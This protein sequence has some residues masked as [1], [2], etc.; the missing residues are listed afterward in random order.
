MGNKPIIRLRLNSNR[1][2]I[3]KT[4]IAS[5]KRRLKIKSSPQ[6]DKNKLIIKNGANDNVSA[7]DSLEF[8]I[9]QS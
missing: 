8:S 1:F 4:F 7:T 5:L 3:F 6:R 2:A 9:R